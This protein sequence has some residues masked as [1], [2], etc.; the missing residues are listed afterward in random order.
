MSLLPAH[1]RS[2]RR[3]AV[4]TA[5]IATVPG[6]LVAMGLPAHASATA[7]ALAGQTGVS[8]WLPVASPPAPPANDDSSISALAPAGPESAWAVGANEYTPSTANPTLTPVAFRWNGRRWRSTPIANPAASEGFGSV[9]DGGGGD[10]WAVGAQTHN[11]QVDLYQPRIRHW[12]GSAWRVTPFP[13]DTQ[14]TDNLQ[15]NQ[16]AAAGG[17]AWIAALDGLNGAILSWHGTS[18]TLQKISSA[19]ELW[20]VTAISVADAWTVGLSSNYSTLALHWNGAT[21]KDESPA[22]QDVNLQDVAA[23]GPDNVWAAGIYY[24]SDNT[25]PFLAADH[26]NGRSWTEYR[27]PDL[28]GMENYVFPLGLTVDHSGEPWIAAYSN[29]ADRTAYFH[30]DGSAWQL[31]YGVSQ[32]GVIESYSDALATLP[33]GGAILS[34]GTSTR[35][36][37]LS[38][39]YA[40][41]NPVPSASSQFTAVPASATRTGK[42]AAAMHPAAAAALAAPSVPSAPATSATQASPRAP[43]VPSMRYGAPL[44]AVRV[45][46]PHGAMPGSKAL[47]A[48]PTSATSARS[49]AT[50]AR[51]AGSSARAAA[52]SFTAAPSVRASRWAPAT[53][54]PMRPQDSLNGVAATTGGS[55]RHPRPIAWAVG[56]QYQGLIAPGDPLVLRSVRG[57]W[58]RVRLPGVRWQGS[59]TGVAAVS[60]TDAWAIGTDVS[61]NPHI[62]HGSR[63]I[64]SDVP[65]PGSTTGEELTAIAAA[66]GVNPWVAGDDANGPVLLH[67]TGSR[68]ASQAAPPGDTGLT[69]LTVHSATDVWAA[70]YA[71]DPANEYEGLVA[72]SH[73]NGSAWTTLSTAG[74]TQWDAASIV[75]AGPDDVW[76]SGGV[77]PFPPYLG[78]LPGPLLAHW[79][80]RSWTQASLPVTLGFLPSLTAAPSRQP[81][82][83]S[84]EPYLLPSGVTIP[85]GSA[86]FLHYTGSAWTFI[87]G[88]ATTP[89]QGNPETYLAAV[90]GTRE[91]LAVGTAPYLLGTH[92]PLIEETHGG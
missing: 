89:E 69:A 16:V 66:T 47:P 59:L 40:E 71:P 88:P 63:G 24:N 26:W 91:T 78:E 72:V 83:A 38:S 45:P 62:L 30:W 35:F 41:L 28:P 92:E 74:T 52:P 13:G 84:V 81:A 5:L 68:W 79:N 19:Y 1:R 76:I 54:P 9:A 20:G 42:T 56:E 12:D 21:W 51:S 80:G 82:W 85:R 31:S 17:R 18:W 58:K 87:F 8:G 57:H 25:G 60:P 90:P 65:F 39:S 48:T 3:A 70:G 61:G 32:P 53:L 4:V 86:V 64:W 75:A 36:A 73:W 23:S 77:W 2:Q 43:A 55:A 46:G 22:N 50:G 49:S 11:P 14:T 44:S 10:V 37:R 27:I 7:A 67:W 29:R 15:L 34:A 6:A 33:D